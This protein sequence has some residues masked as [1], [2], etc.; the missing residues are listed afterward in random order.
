MLNIAKIRAQFPAL[1]QEVHGHPLVYLDN[2][3][4]T[5]KP[6]AVIDAIQQ[7][8]AE[9]NSNIHRGVHYLS[10]LAT[11]A[12]E[13][14]RT[15][16]QKHLNAQHS[17][18]IIFTRGITE[19]INLVAHGFRSVLKIGDEIIV[20]TIEHHSNIVPWQM[21]CD[22]TGAKLQIIP[23]DENGALKMDAFHALLS[24]KTKLVA[25]NHISNAL[26]TINPIK[27]M[28]DAA[29]QVGA[30]ILIDGAQAA[31]HLSIDVQELDA[32]FYCISGHK[33]YAPTGIGALY[34]KE[35]WLNKIPP[36]QG[37]GEMIA[38]V[39]FEET[40]YADLPH[41]FEAGTPNIAGGVAFK[42]AIDWLNEI[43]LENIAQ[44][45]SKLLQYASERLSEIDGFRLIGNAP[46]KAGV[47]S[48][49]INDL[50]PYDIGMILDKLGIAVR[51][52]H[53]C[54]QPVMD[55]FCIPGTVRASLAIYNTK[56]DVDRLVEGVK[57]AK[58]M[59]S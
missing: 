32:D 45:E 2:G 26:G 51:T 48:F 31:P 40:T 1:H 37:G 49:M 16:I 52:G 3:A 58:S 27:E 21:A 20:S 50:H 43:G 33:M 22:A 4:T 7:Y 28:I 23:M 8:Y 34:G 47:I 18:E 14:S 53:H 56:D 38:T 44:Y 25:V 9:Q 29:H 57:K 24:E 17:H 11:D 55:A 46:Q 54:A 39:S 13:A 19:A 59:L 6:Q 12:Y 42:T 36:Y 15:C 35:K 41:K 10:Q 5:Q 30:A